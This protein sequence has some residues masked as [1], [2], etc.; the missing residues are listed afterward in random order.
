MKRLKMKLETQSL[1]TLRA[2]DQEAETV[3]QAFAEYWIVR[4]CCPVNLHGDQESNF[5]S[6]LLRS[7]CSE[8]GTTL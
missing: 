2:N 1:K 6:K 8:L 4:L 5:M 7:P 3:A